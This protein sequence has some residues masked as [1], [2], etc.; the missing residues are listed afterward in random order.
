[1]N[2]IL[3]SLDDSKFHLQKGD[4]IHAIIFLQLWESFQLKL[5]T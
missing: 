1:M 2:K 5:G 4:Y 3:Y